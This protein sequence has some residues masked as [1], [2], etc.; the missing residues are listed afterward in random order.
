MCNGANLCYNKNAFFKINGFKGNSNIASGD[1]V[2]LMEKMNTSFPKKIVFVKSKEV[3]VKTKAEK[4]LVSFYNQQVRWAGKSTAY[5]SAFSKTVSI[6]VLLISVVLIG[7]MIAS[8]LN[9][10]YWKIL[11]VIFTLKLFI[12]FILINKTATFLNNT[13]SLK[14]YLLTSVFYPFYITFTGISSLFKNYEWKGRQFK[15]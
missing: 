12:D 1:D 3:I 5:N 9:P 10:I 2:F 13:S 15:K 14:Y 11:I 7:L 4:N 6:V 8:I